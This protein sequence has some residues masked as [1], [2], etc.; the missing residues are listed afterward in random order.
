M[1]AQ[2]TQA[3]AG[4]DWNLILTIVAIAWGTLQTL[5]L[6][7]VAARQSE[8]KD[9]KDKLEAATKCQVN[10]L[11]NAWKEQCAMRHASIEKRLGDGDDHFETVDQRTNDIRLQVTREMGTVKTWM[12]QTFVT[13]E[14]LEK[15]V[16]AMRHTGSQ[17]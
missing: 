14:D 17:N 3:A 5:G 15:F 13:K 2:A 12:M 6:A 1:L 9:L 10:D 16:R 7:Y 4:T 8:I 11:L